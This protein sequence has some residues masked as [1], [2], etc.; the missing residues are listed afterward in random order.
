MA[1]P[2]R[3]LGQQQAS[4]IFPGNGAFFMKNLSCL[5]DVTNGRGLRGGVCTLA[6]AWLGL[7]TLA[8]AP[9]P[10]PLPPEPDFDA[11]RLDRPQPEEWP[12]AAPYSS[13]ASAIIAAMRSAFC[14]TA[15][16]GKS[17]WARAMRRVLLM[18]SP[19]KRKAARGGLSQARTGRDSTSSPAWQSPRPGRPG[20]AP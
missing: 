10:T 1:Y 6:A 11:S 12:V 2:L 3:R 16:T 20:S 9:L 14:A 5:F 13:R 17:N 15:P 18:R 19:D 8:A 4:F 7:T